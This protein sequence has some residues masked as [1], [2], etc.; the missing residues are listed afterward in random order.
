MVRQPYLQMKRRSPTS[1]D[2][3]SAAVADAAATECHPKHSVPT[4]EAEEA[5][6]EAAKEADEQQAEQRRQT[7]HFPRPMAAQAPWSA[8][9]GVPRPRPVQPTQQKQ[10]AH[11]EKQQGHQTKNRIEDIPIQ[12]DLAPPPPP[13]AR[14]P[15]LAP[16]PRTWVALS[17]RV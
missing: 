16:H 11:E 13:A 14:L 7:P 15:R 12:L 2:A 8:K 17:A 4:Q 1:C 9:R 10:N 3:S 6:A 5:E